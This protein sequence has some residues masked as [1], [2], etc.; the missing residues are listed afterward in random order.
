MTL[1]KAVNKGCLLAVIAALALLAPVAFS[2]SPSA[3]TVVVDARIYTVNSKQPW[4]QALAI[5]GGKI[6]A[7]G[8]AKQIEVYRAASTKVLDGKGY[9]L[10]P[11][12]TDSHIHFLDGSL[13]LL[14]VNLSDAKTIPEIQKLVRDYADKNPSE[15]WVL[16]RGW[17]YP[18]F[19]PSGLPDKKYLDE[20]IPDRPVYLEAFDG[21]SWWAN[22]KALQLAGVTAKTSDPPNGRI[23]RDPATGE[24]TG[25]IQ[26]DA[27]DAVVRRAIPLPTR[28]EK[29][30]ALRAGLQE[31][32]RVGLVRVH[33]AG[34][35]NIGSS[36]LQNVDLL[37]EL[38]KTGQLTVR[39]YLAY[40][41]DPPALTH[42][43]LA[44]IKAA[45]RRYHD[46]WIAAGA[47]K[48]F[49]DGVVEG[50]TAA[51]LTPYTDDPKQIGALFWDPAK[52]KQAVERLDRGGFQV[53]T[54]AIGDK[55]VRLALDSYESAAKV[56]HTKDAR[57]R[58]EHVETIAGE[59]IPQFGKVGVI[60]SFQPLHAYPDD[61]TLNI[62]ARNVGPERAQRAWAWHSIESAGGVL[63]FG[64]DWPVVTLNP[65]PGV[66]NALTRQTVDGNPPEGFVPKERISLEDA[67]KAYTLG[68]AIAGRREKTE[69][70]LDPGKVADLIIVS[71]DL[72]KIEPSDIGKTEVMLTMVGGKVVYQSPHWGEAK[73]AAAGKVE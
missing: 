27:A 15:P 12:F 29:L 70:S 46:E 17:Q 18:V 5:R 65:W 45:R 4:A 24:P 22:S 52:Y 25:A 73:N 68:A 60:A 44:E 39:M 54:H 72:F 38:R 49:L 9:L 67:I 40:R 13:S 58:V 57:H 11:G 55:A 47:V 48:F 37:D 71:Q 2:Q 64:S 33:S 51:M 21:H 23:A 7:I 42:K 6:V 28:E 62:W 59:D 31:A 36:D 16:G 10:L 56:N 53:F 14:R 26:E 50:H 19:A 1:N 8:S 30:R 66:Q 32:N 3:D 61:D 41:L 34:G 69:G 20:I 43:Q 35:V 63:A